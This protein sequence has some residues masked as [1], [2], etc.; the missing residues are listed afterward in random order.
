[1]VRYPL[2]PENGWERTVETAIRSYQTIAEQYP[3]HDM[4]LMGDS[5]G[6][7]L[8]MVLNAALKQQSQHQHHNQAEKQ[9][10][11]MP[12]GLVL[13]SP[14]LDL[15]N[16]LEQSKTSVIQESRCYGRLAH[17]S[18]LRYA[19]TTQLQHAQLSP[20]YGDLSA[21]PATLV[22]YGENDLVAEDCQRLKTLLAENKAQGGGEVT[23]PKQVTFE[24]Y[25]GMGHVWFFLPIVERQ[26]ALEQVCGFVQTIVAR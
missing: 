8:A 19:R 5:A 11:Q 10:V 12:M 2:A 23:T 1:M 14:W 7:G 16:K 22:L 9:R 21:L 24:A 6:A 13:L 20:L 26:K 18:A 25:T 15:S 4:V 3:D 17:R